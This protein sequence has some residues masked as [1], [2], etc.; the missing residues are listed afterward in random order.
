MRYRFTPTRMTISKRTDGNK[1]EQGCGETGSLV[2]CGG[3]VK[4]YRHFGKVWQLFK[5]FHMELPH[6]LRE[7]KTYIHTKNLYVNDQSSI[8]PNGQNVETTKTSITWRMAKQNLA[9]PY[10]G[11]WFSNKEQCSP[12]TRS[13]VDEP[14]KRHAKWRE[15]VMETNHR[16]IPFTRKVWDKQVYRNRR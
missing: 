15:L 16:R 10:N 1:H 3:N 4:C 12:D 2:H 8:T 14:W 11:V 5:M 13:D 7:T 9:Y 6:D